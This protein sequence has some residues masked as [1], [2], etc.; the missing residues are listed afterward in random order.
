MN[1]LDRIHEESQG[2]GEDFAKAYCN[3]LSEL[4]SKL[5]YSKI[6]S[7]AEKLLE[8]REKEQRIIFMGNGGSAATA[9][10]F[11]NDLSIGP[12]DFDKPFRALSLTDN[13]PVMTAIAN[14]FGYED[15]FVLQLKSLLKP[16]DVVVAISAS[17]NSPNIVKA[18]EYAKDQGAYIVGLSGFD[19]G[20]L[21]QMADLSICIETPKGEYG[22]V[23][24][25][26]MVLDHL[27]GAYLMRE[28]RSRA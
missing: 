7:F 27:L 16:K 19:G 4:L 22:P 13:V 6:S 17:G 14:D 9:S 5:D 20:K 24:D 18:L 21:A 25:L 11:A 1:T 2:R 3:Y 12:R 10:H 15:I 8:A 26:H 23:E 28:I